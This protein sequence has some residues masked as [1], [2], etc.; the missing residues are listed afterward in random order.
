M[1]TRK[2]Y[3]QTCRIINSDWKN[4]KLPAHC[5]SLALTLL[6]TFLSSD[7]HRVKSIYTLVLPAE[8]SQIYRVQRFD[9]VQEDFGL[10]GLTENKM[11]FVA[12][13]IFPILGQ[14]G[15][16][17]PAHRANTHHLSTVYTAVHSDPEISP[18]QYQS[19][20]H[21]CHSDLLLATLLYHWILH[22][23]PLISDRL[24]VLVWVNWERLDLL[25]WINPALYVG[26][27]L[28][29][30]SAHMLRVWHV[31]P[32]TSPGIKRIV[33]GCNRRSH[34]HRAYHRQSSFVLCVADGI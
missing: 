33:T 30:S 9:S 24:Y 3:R 34:P 14:I 19:S 1:H 2:S 4:Q 29:G 12:R 21:P 27:S 22:K 20:V 23:P 17:A 16:S 31:C 8:M 7:L 11:E 25:L 6:S 26:P 15:I 13:S 28:R 5:S 18:C 32:Y 10:V